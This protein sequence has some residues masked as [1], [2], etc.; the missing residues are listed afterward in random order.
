MQC[1]GAATLT[2]SGIPDR[3][4][5]RR[6]WHAQVGTAGWPSRSNNGM[7]VWFSVPVRGSRRAVSTSER[8][9]IVLG[10]RAWPGF[11]VSPLLPEEFENPIAM[12]GQD[13]VAEIV[14]QFEHGERHLRWPEPGD[15]DGNRT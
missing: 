4:S 3:R 9:A 5:A 13:F 15:F 1:G 14:D 6:L 7:I 11:I 10:I 2:P 12:Q 8:L